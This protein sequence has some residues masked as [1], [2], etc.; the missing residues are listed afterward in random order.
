MNR[1]I[2]KVAAATAFAS[3]VLV[4][5][6][7]AADPSAPERS[8]VGAWRVSLTPRN[9]QTGD[10]IPAPGAPYQGLYTFHKGGTMSEWVTNTVVLPTLRGPGHGAWRKAAGW[11]TYSY[12][13]VF[14]RYD[15][16]GNYTGTQ[17][18][19]AVLVL[20]ESGNDY[21]TTGTVQVLDQNGNV[22]VASCSTIDAQR[23]E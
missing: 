5:T 1:N 20:G 10:A 21:T 15:T 16:S 6:A 19:R 8:L 13:F 18:G 12:T 9:C 7:L 23:I 22:L 2:L 17:H 4:G 11:Q 14:D 3:L